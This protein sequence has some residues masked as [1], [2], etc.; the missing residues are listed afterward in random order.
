MFEKSSSLQYFAIMLEP[1]PTTTRVIIPPI[2][3]P[4]PNN[5]SAAVMAV[6][7]PANPV[8]DITIRK[9]KAGIPIPASLSTNSSIKKLHFDLEFFVEIRVYEDFHKWIKSNSFVSVY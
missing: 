9:I 6:A 7:A 1:A 4:G 2:I 5:A 8:V 3:P